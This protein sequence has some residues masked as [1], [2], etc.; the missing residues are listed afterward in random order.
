MSFIDN[1]INEIGEAI[2]SIDGPWIDLTDR[3]NIWRQD[4]P[5]NQY[6]ELPIE[7]FP[8]VFVYISNVD[9]ELVANDRFE[10]SVN[11]DL[12]IRY[13]I[14]PKTEKRHEGI[15]R[16]RRCLQQ[17]V[18]RILERQT[19]G[20]AITPLYLSGNINIESVANGLID[21]KKTDLINGA[22]TAK[23]TLRQLVGSD[24][25]ATASVSIDIVGNGKA[26][27]A[28]TYEIGAM[29]NLIASPL[30]GWDF[31]SWTDEYTGEEFDTLQHSFS[32]PARDVSIKALFKSSAEVW[33]GSINTS[34]HDPLFSEYD[35]YTASQLAGLASLVR[36]GNS[37]SGKTINLRADI[38][39]NDVDNWENSFVPAGSTV[40]EGAFNFNGYGVYGTYFSSSSENILS[41]GS[42]YFGGPINCQ[43][44]IV[45][46]D[47]LA[48]AEIAA[49]SI[50]I[51]GNVTARG[52][53]S[54]LGDML[55]DGNLVMENGASLNVSNYSTIVL[56]GSVWSES[57]LFSGN[58]TSDKYDSLRLNA[59]N[60]NLIVPG[61][62]LNHCAD[63]TNR[64]CQEAPER[65]YYFISSTSFIHF[66][67]QT[68]RQ[69]PT[70]LNRPQGAIMWE[71]SHFNQQEEQNA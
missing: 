68:V 53:I 58:N 33:D 20:K 46:G 34:W 27:G 45:M 54:V 69:D 3:D 57:P 19:E 10:N 5:L 49:D 25:I 35:I 66:T 16:G 65:W 42:A 50:R 31:V 60:K 1:A 23:F 28:G 14:D 4:M 56:A 26:I 13:K 9:A 21:H 8:A 12:A 47:M 38:K 18:K 61:T 70:E 36:D 30:S 59:P 64:N 11:I 2:A 22:A 51:E 32:M 52:I 55:I 43:N 24:P 44:I 71:Y 7:K 41:F 17:I 63:K 67:S 37:F 6:V 62:Y 48:G 39:L 15:E 29:V 40:F